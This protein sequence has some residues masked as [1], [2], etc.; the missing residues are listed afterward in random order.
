MIG[1]IASVGCGVLL[2]VL[3]IVKMGVERLP[4]EEE[5]ARRYKEETSR[6]FWRIQHGG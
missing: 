6:N 2:G 4:S 5:A 3:L 1:V